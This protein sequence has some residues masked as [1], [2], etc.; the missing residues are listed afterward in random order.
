ME[1]GELEQALRKQSLWMAVLN[2]VAN[3]LPILAIALI[4]SLSLLVFQSR[5]A[6]VLPNLVTFVLALQR[7]NQ[8]LSGVANT[9]TTITENSSR[10]QRLNDILGENDKQFRRKGGRPFQ[11]LHHSVRFEDVG[12]Q[13]R[14]G[15]P[16]ALSHLSFT[17]AKGQ[18]LALV[19]ASGAGKSSIADLLTGL[20]SPST[21]KIWIDDT[22]LDQLDLNS[23]QQRLGVVSQDTFLFN[24]T[25]AENI[26]FGMPGATQ[27]QIESACQSAQAAGFIES[28]PQAYNT[29]VG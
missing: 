8:R 21:G 10:L 16:A 15:L 22:P 20:Y 11:R 23:W 25:I 6:G 14:P 13:Y 1:M 27:R 5:S 18:M 17:L 7:L 19:G 24:A 28:L 4:I 2:P 29:L 26:A 12:L 3:F 9:F